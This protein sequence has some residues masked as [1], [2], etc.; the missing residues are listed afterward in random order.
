[1]GAFFSCYYFGMAVLPVV[2]GEVR[3][4]AG[5]PA[6]PI[7]FAAVMILCSL[8]LLLTF[9]AL[10]RPRREVKETRFA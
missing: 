8:F 5:D 3:D 9:R 2:A 7:L 10:Q 1:M 6:A 4:V